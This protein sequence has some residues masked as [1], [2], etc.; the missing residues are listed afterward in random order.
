MKK[1]VCLYLDD[2]SIVYLDQLNVKTLLPKSE[3]TRK[4]LHYFGKEEN[5]EELQLI[6][7][8]EE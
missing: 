5:F 7:N 2:V 1:R 6:L 3:I 4:L 8:D